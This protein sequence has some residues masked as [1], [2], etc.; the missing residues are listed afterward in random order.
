[1]KRFLLWSFE[2]GS[3]QYDVICGIILTFIFWPLA[4]NDRPD[5]M[6]LSGPAQ[7]RRAMD[8][9]QNTVYTVKVERSLFS[10]DPAVSLD[11][12]LKLLRAAVGRPIQTTLSKPLYDTM[13]RLNAYAIWVKEGEDVTGVLK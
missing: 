7:V 6:K 4:F 9:E 2:R 10:S 8:D 13:G 5:Y 1:M 12:A 11:A 3:M